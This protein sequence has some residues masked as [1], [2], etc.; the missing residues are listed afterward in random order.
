MK[1]FDLIIVPSIREPL[2]NVVI[3]AALQKVPIIASTVDGIVEIIDNNISGILIKPSV[4][5]NKRFITE[6][7]PLPEYVVDVENERLIK[8]M[9]LDPEKLAELIKYMHDNQDIAIIS[10]SIVTN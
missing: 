8:P 10:E 2:G 4:D 7:V 5:V 3:E 9:Q 6:S 1:N